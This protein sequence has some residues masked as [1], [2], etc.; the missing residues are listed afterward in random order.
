ME[1]LSLDERAA[2]KLRYNKGMRIAEIAN[3]LGRS[4]EAVAMLI[5][6][7]RRKLRERL[8]SIRGNESS[9]DALA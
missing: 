6:R 4:P 3:R 7:A 9:S 8:T 1:R 2:L 5:V